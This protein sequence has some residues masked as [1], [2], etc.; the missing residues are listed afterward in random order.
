MILTPSPVSTSKFT[1]AKDD[2]L[3]VAEASDLPH[4]G[5]VWDDA[6]DTGLTLISH[7]TG[8]MVV[9]AVDHTE[10]LDGDLLYWDLV[11][12]DRRNDGLIKV[13]VFND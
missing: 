9:M 10:Y 1:Y 6:C 4:F 3:L 12:A 7:Q 11:P 2:N 5:Q 13:R 8:R